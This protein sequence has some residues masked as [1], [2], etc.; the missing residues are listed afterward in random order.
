MDHR[1]TLLLRFALLF[2]ISATASGQGAETP[3]TLSAEP[4]SNSRGLS[5]MTIADNVH[6]ALGYGSTTMAMI[7][8][9]DGVVIIDSL[10]SEAAAARAMEAFREITTKPIQ[11]LILTHRH[12]DHS[13]G[14]DA[15]LEGADMPVYSRPL[16]RRERND[17]FPHAENNAPTADAGEY[18]PDS[19]SGTAASD[20]QLPI[21]SRHAITVAG[22]DLEL[23]PAR[24]DDNQQ[25]WLWYPAKGVLFS[26][27]GFYTSFP[28]IHALG[29]VNRETR[30]W[31]ATLDAMLQQSPRFLVTGHG[32]PIIGAEQSITALKDYRDAMALV[33][34]ETLAGIARGLGPDALIAAVTLPP[35]LDGLPYLEQRFSRLSWAVRALYADRKGWFDGNP[36]HLDG[37]PP[38]ALAAH[39]A[40]LS[41]GAEVLFENGLLA[42][43]N[44][45]YR[46]A[47]QLAD[48]LI[49]LDPASS[50]AQ[51]MKADA[52]VGLAGETPTLAA[53][54][55]YLQS[56]RTLRQSAI[57]E[58]AT[59]QESV[60]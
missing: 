35:E 33:L 11:A 57:N 17:T 60:D 38:A 32:Y 42:L 9:A 39:I 5:V 4:L 15:V 34:E 6:I 19:S 14:L 20:P 22:I 29:D 2:A 45:D 18:P 55:F 13:G 46:W 31:L 59:G 37:L 10:D 48:Y 30:D 8:G 47:A 44:G 23:V 1:F 50:P 21:T 51:H 54:D 53:R 24:G 58:D 28:A 43:D 7:E 26:G 36:T 49:A 41:G 3:A 25:L 52:L 27:D 56:A 12:Q 16:P 40:E